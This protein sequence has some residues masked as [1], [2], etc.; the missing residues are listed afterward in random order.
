MK[1]A[2]DIVVSALMLILLSPVML[3][4]GLASRIMIGPGIFFRQ[5]RLGLGETPFH[6]IKFRTMLNAVGSDGQLLPDDERLT[7]YGRFLR[8]TSLDELP[9]LFNVLTGEMSLVGPRPLLPVYRE[10]YSARQRRRHLVR[11]GVTGLAQVNGRNAVAWS[12]RLAWDVEYV[13][14][15]SLVGDLRILFKTVALVLSRQGIS[16]EGSATMPAFTGE[17][18]DP[19]AEDRQKQTLQTTTAAYGKAADRSSNKE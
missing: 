5:E 4:V 7:R 12:E 14:N 9:E 18:D 2:L 8:A 16:A 17:P 1:R 10:R 6:I 13:D 3:V 19:A 15:H 11:P